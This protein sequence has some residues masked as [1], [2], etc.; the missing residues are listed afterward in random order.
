M[1][2]KKQK[3]KVIY[4]TIKQA[5]PSV[6]TS[7]IKEEIADLE[8]KKKQAS[9][10]KKGFRKFFTGV[11]YNKEIN[12]RRKILGTVQGTE[13][14]RGQIQLLKQ[15][16]ELEKAKTEFKEAQKKNQVNFGSGN[17][18]YESLFK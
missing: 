9:E 12:E 7:K 1:A 11:G 5:A 4:R 2:K 18:S 3:T 13:K 6:D 8:S 16:T 15:R 10:G 14:A 17:I